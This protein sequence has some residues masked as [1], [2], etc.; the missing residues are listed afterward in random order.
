[1]IP[2]KAI[3]DIPIRQRRIN[4]AKGLRELIKEEDM[5]ALFFLT[6]R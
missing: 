5:D 1:M 3:S 4:R 6:N 2:I